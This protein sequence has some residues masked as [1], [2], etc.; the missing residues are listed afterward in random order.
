MLIR[1]S[2]DYLRSHWVPLAIA[3]VFQ[4]AQTLIGL[5]LPTLNAHIIDEGIVRTDTGVILRAGGLMLAAA[6]AQICLAAV[7]AL[8]AAKVCMGLGRHLRERMFSQVLAFS[9]TQ[10]RQFGP[11]SL[12]TRTTN[13]ISQIYMVLLVMFT[14]VL[15]APIMGIG[16]L[17][18]V[19]TMDLPLATVLLV[20]IPLDLLVAAVIMKKLVPLFE[21]KQKRIDRVGEVMREQL[22]GVRVIRAFVRQRSE[23]YRFALA[24][25]D[26][27]RVALAEGLWFAVLTPLVQAIMAGAIGAVLFFGAGRIDTGALQI[28]QLVAFLTYLLSILVAVIMASLFLILIPHAEVSAKRVWEVLETTPDLQAPASPAPLPAGPLGVRIEGVRAAYPGAERAVLEHITLT[29]APGTTTAIVG[30]IGSGKSTL[31]WLLPRLA[32]PSAGTL[33]LVGGDSEVD[34]R[35]LALPEVR[36]TVALVPQRAYLMRGTIATT[37]ASL[38]PTALTP[39][40]RARVRTCLEAAAALDFVDA[41]A[42]GIDHEV[43]SGG[44]N[45]SGGQRQRLTLARA[46]FAAPRIL[47]SD[48]GFSA[49]D[50]TTEAAV[51]AAIPRLLPQV[52]QV[53]VA[54]RLASIRHADQICVID[55][56]R[57]VGLGTHDDLL[58]TCP[59][60]GELV[61]SQLSEEE[62]A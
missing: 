5:T 27:R 44:A 15:S 32:D 40:V 50:F 6:T 59:L 57:I 25:D 42:D 9:H 51:R 23:S 39:E 14:L 37:V 62:V 43:T 41:F 7:S 31:A 52:T 49:L 45:L 1:L 20:A 24:N 53:V 33:T 47:V 35:D 19:L 54:Q 38:P 2:W 28:G 34:L 12:I 21:L 61:A 3:L 16:A 18:V 58:A 46:F 56:G 36:R 30:P 26:L 55:E 17:V 4:V 60:Y 8:W 10:L 11:S 29:C 13:D 22:T 48:D